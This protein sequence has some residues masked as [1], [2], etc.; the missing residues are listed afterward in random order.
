MNA[1]YEYIV[2]VSD[3]LGIHI[4]PPDTP[5]LYE[6]VTKYIENEVCTKSFH[7]KI[8]YING[9]IHFKRY[10]EHC[11]YTEELEYKEI[12][13]IQ[14]VHNVFAR[15]IKDSY[16]DSPIL[17]NG[18]IKADEPMSEFTIAYLKHPTY[19][20]MGKYENP[21]SSE[22]VRVYVR[23]NMEECY[24]EYTTEVVQI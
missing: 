1:L 22:C 10:V 7:E 17:Y 9:S 14:D 6:D 4:T 23:R 16:Y 12:R 3:I 20:Y 15:F 11:D 24:N 8:L 19:F 13:T 21:T 18:L 5:C 2:N